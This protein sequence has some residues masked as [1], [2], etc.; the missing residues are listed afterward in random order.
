MIRKRRQKGKQNHYCLLLNSAAANYRRGAVERLTAALRK[1]GT[2]YTIVEPESAPDLLKMAEQA[3]GQ[4]R[5]G[6]YLSQNIG[7]RGKITGLIACGGDGTFNLAARAAMAADLPVGVLPMGR[8]NNIARSLFG[9]EGQDAAIKNIVSGQY[10]KIDSARAGDQMFFGS[11]A[12]GYVPRLMLELDDRKRPRFAI[13]WEHL[14]DQAAAEIE[15]VRSVIKVE[16]FRFELS[17]LMININLLPYSAGLPFSPAS[18]VDDG[19]AEVIFDHGNE[20]TDF[21]TYTR[22]L[23]KKKYLYGNEIRLYRGSVIAVQPASG[24]TLYLDGELIQVPNN[25]LE[26]R[27]GPAQVKV[28]C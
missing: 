14:G 10:R 19:R 8:M 3:A 15:A 12:L 23:F 24:R 21:G 2:Y 9:S 25:V 16:S 6:K 4:R 26:V 5:R 11:I 7:R 18:A 1:V 20:S 17:P 13:G 22:Q 28:F 27:V